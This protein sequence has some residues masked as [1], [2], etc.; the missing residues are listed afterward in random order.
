MKKQ[1]NPTANNVKLAPLDL[2]ALWKEVAGDDAEFIVKKNEVGS[3]LAILVAFSEET[4]GRLA[5]K[6]SWK[7][8][9]ITK[10]LSGGENLTLRTIF[11]LARALG[12]DFQI[13]LKAIG[14]HRIP[15]PWEHQACVTDIRNNW[16]NAKA[17]LETAK[18]INRQSFRMP[19][20]AFQMSTRGAANENN[21]AALSTTA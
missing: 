18:A 20:V 2:S 16:I 12:Y 19:S 17:M 21:N 10:V 13:V 11:E 15:Q 5:E 7:E 8:S 1:T 4:R 14:Q 3:D 6:L 9:R